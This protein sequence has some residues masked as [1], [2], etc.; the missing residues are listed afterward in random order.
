MTRYISC[1]TKITSWWMG[2]TRWS[3]MVDRR[4]LLLSVLFPMVYLPNIQLNRWHLWKCPKSL[5][6]QPLIYG[7]IYN[8]SICDF[9]QYRICIYAAAIAA[10]TDRQILYREFPVCSLAHLLNKHGQE[11]VSPV[12]SG[13]TGFLC[14]PAGNFDHTTSISSHKATLSVLTDTRSGPAQVHIKPVSLKR[15]TSCEAIT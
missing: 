9:P 11:K 14:P 4:K 3:T 13:P 2:E 12:F 1:V 8:G 7:T 6:A 5:C 10:T 15:C